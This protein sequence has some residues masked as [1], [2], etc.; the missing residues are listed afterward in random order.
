[1]LNVMID[2][3]VKLNDFVNNILSKWGGKGVE[4]CR[5]KCLNIAILTFVTFEISWISFKMSC[6]SSNGWLDT[7]RLSCSLGNYIDCHTIA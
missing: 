6:I 4:S 1:M 3:E 2:V 7:L 5:M